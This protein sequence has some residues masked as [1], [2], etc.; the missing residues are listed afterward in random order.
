[1]KYEPL[2]VLKNE[3]GHLLATVLVNKLEIMTI[4]ATDGT[5]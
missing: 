2:G 5:G 1:M 4:K 3:E